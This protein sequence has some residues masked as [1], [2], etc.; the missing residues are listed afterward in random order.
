MN[1]GLMA[2]A[3]NAGMEAD[4]RQKVFDYEQ[5]RRD[6][7][8]SLLDDRTAAER[9]GY[10][11]RNDQNT[12]N[13]DLLPTQTTNAKSRLT[14]EAADLQGQSDRQP[15]ELKAKATNA[16]IGVTNADIGLS[17]AE[18]DKANVPSALAVKNNA[19]QSQLMTSQAD[20][21]AL[22]GKIQRAT[23]QGVLDQRGQ[24]EVVLGTLGQLISRQDKAGALA[25]ANEIAKV[26]DILPNTNGKTFT[27][28]VPVRKGDNGAPGDGYVFHTSDGNKVFTPVETISGAM[29]KIKSGEY[30]FLHTNDG[31]VFS[32]NKQTGA[33]TQVHQGDTKLLR[34]QHTPAEIQT[35]EYLVS[36]GVAKDTNQAWEMVRSSREKT[37]NSFITD[38]VAKNALNPSDAPKV[39]EQ[40]GK[41]YDDLRKTQEPAMRPAPASNP[42]PMSNTPMPGTLDPQ[43]KSLLGLP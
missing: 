7:E 18:N 1:L 3:A 43:I 40:A 14:L 35:M 2:V 10:Q 33:V 8:L 16:K 25:F 19:L 28:I 11:L 15:D 31:S 29:Q 27:D 21:K 24:G 41:I 26:G 32:G 9:S 4:R 12:A 36:K 6:A 38:F 22:P 17:N 5:K 13:R 34:G 39:A 23:V 20:I 30:Q 37:R 42:P